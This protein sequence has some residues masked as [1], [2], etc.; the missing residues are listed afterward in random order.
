MAT[1][2]VGAGLSSFGGMVGA[3]MGVNVGAQL[4]GGRGWLAVVVW[5]RACCVDRLARAPSSCSH[6]YYLGG[7][8]MKTMALASTSDI[9]KD[10]SGSLIVSL[11]P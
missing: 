4:G 10:L 11:T 5:T 7:E 3:G 8:E 2:G 9:R 1:A 6:L